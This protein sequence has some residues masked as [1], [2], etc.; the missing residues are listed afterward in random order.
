MAMAYRNDQR[1]PVQ[2][3]RPNTYDRTPLRESGEVWMADRNL[4]VHVRGD[5]PVDQLLQHEERVV[6]QERCVETTQERVITVPRER[7]VE[8]PIDRVKNI[9]KLVVIERPKIERVEKVVTLTRE[10]PVEKVV[11]KQVVRKVTVERIIERPREVIKEV[12]V[13]K[14]VEKVIEVVKQVPVEK[15]IERIQIKEIPV[16]ETEE[17]IVEVIK[18]VP[19]MIVKEVPVYV[20]IDPAEWEARH[21]LTHQQSNAGVGILLA[22]NRGGSMNGHNEEIYVME[23]VPGSPAAECGLIQVDDILVAIEGQAINAAWSLPR[24]FDLMKGREGTVVNLVFS[25]GGREYNVALRRSA[26]TTA[27]GAGYITANEGRSSG[28]R[29]VAADYHPAAK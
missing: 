22:K 28:L 14:I 15:V 3:V 23:I 26:F 7:I 12:P 18:E 16:V 8:K 29:I 17:R 13:E 6:S 21:G 19:I 11:E 20:K 24:I 2:P 5:E 1:N 25:R 4:P 27:G 9:D 10:V